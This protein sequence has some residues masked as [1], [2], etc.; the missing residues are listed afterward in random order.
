MQPFIKQDSLLIR[1]N[2]KGQKSDLW[3]CQLKNKSLNLL[4]AAIRKTAMWSINYAF[5]GWGSYWGF[6]E[7]IRTAKP[8]Y[9]MEMHFLTTDHENV[10]SETFDSG[11]VKAYCKV[12][13][14]FSW[15]EIGEKNEITD[16]FR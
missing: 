6:C 16:H 5:I 7:F 9:Y 12:F 2:N 14:G 10:S 1:A 8:K 15:T 3:L 11:P 13:I 4:T